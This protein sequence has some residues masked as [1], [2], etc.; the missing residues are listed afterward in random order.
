MVVLVPVSN[1]MSSTGPQPTPVPLHWHCKTPPLCLVVSANCF[2]RL[3]DLH[4]LVYPWKLPRLNNGLRHL[5]LVF[6]WPSCCIVVGA[7]CSQGNLWS[8]DPGFHIHSQSVM[9]LLFNTV[10]PETSSLVQFAAFFGCVSSRLQIIFC[11]T[12]SCFTSVLYLCF[13]SLSRDPHP[14]IF[15]K[16]RYIASVYS[17]NCTGK[18]VP[19]S[20]SAHALWSV[21]GRPCTLVYR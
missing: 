12:P 17:S 7:S 14:H 8:G 20:H 6:M 1:R 4:H 21:R 19:R 3:L 2:L 9:T 13:C 18:G 10:Q 11:Y 5:Y 16:F 15:S